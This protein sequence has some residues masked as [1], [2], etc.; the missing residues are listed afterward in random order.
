MAL[1]GCYHDRN[2]TDNETLVEWETYRLAFANLH[3]FYHGYHS[4]HGYLSS[5]VC[6]LGALMNLVNLV[7]LTR[8]NMVNTVNVVLTA[9]A[10][11]DVCLSLAYLVYLSHFVLLKANYFLH[12]HCDPDSNTYGWALFQLFYAN[13]SSILHAI[14]L[15]LAVGMAALR[16]VILS[17]LQPA[18]ALGLNPAY[19]LVGLSTLLVIICSVPNFLSY[20]VQE[21][22]YRESDCI[23]TLQADN[24]V[25]YEAKIQEFLDTNVIIYTLI[26]RD[27]TCALRMTSFW[28]SG[29]FLKILPCAM[30]SVF[31]GLLLGTMFKVRCD[32]QECPPSPMH[33][34]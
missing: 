14:S 12:F 20:Q 33:V 15:W 5:G 28:L 23:L 29:L 11:S 32:A 9:I 22:R 27:D 21:V 2:L 31:M 26:L 13:L 17:R 1:R 6:A 30:L 34:S 25:D 10:A 4:T 16:Y 18:S 19:A 8:P 24:P 7:V 3:D